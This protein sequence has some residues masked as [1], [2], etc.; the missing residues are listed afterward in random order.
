[1]QKIEK[2]LKNNDIA[3][4]KKRDRETGEVKEL[5]VPMETMQL[6]LLLFVVGFP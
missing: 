1:M 6:L 5:P 4:L 2:S 3:S